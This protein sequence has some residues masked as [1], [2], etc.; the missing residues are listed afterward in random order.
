MEDNVDVY[1][2]VPSGAVMVKLINPK[3]LFKAERLNR[4]YFRQVHSAELV[5]HDVPVF[6]EWLSSIMTQANHAKKPVLLWN[7]PL[8]C[9]NT[10]SKRMSFDSWWSVG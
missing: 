10:S 3:L 4:L 5:G 6:D 8:L 9:P 7:L 1:D 2:L